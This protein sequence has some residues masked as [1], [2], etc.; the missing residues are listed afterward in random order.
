MFHLFL[1]RFIFDLPL[2]IEDVL[3]NPWD[4]INQCV[5]EPKIG[6]IAERQC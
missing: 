3:A 5:L 2:T 4:F 1:L 6:A